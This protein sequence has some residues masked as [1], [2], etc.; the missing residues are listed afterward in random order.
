MR[1][2]LP[3]LS[4]RVTRGKWPPELRF[5]LHKMQACTPRRAAAEV[6]GVPVGVLSTASGPWAVGSHGGDDTEGG[7]HEECV[8]PGTAVPEFQGPL[9]SKPMSTRKQTR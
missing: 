3:G 2:P 1:S 9:A 6:R 4:P 5:L 8:C 7:D